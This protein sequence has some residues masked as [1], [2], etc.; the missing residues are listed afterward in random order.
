MEDRTTDMDHI[1][2]QSEMGEI[3]AQFQ[4]LDDYR[5]RVTNA[6]KSAAT[7]LMCKG[8]E[9]TFQMTKTEYTQENTIGMTDWIQKMKG[10][11]AWT[12]ATTENKFFMVCG[13][14][15]TAGMKKERGEVSQYG[16]VRMT[17][18]EAKEMIRANQ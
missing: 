14:I 1:L 3:C 11:K 17:K 8:F 13:Y 12:E 10:K 16:S 5:A 7:C 18:T 9:D 4:N 2:M 6:C 15:A